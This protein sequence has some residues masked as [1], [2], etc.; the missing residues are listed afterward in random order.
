MRW[1]DS[2]QFRRRSFSLALSLISISHPPFFS[3]FP[4]FFYYFFLAKT[5]LER[6]RLCVGSPHHPGLPGGQEHGARASQPGAFDEAA[7]RNLI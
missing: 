1:G 5:L 7:L 4:L 2:E 3:F 6:H